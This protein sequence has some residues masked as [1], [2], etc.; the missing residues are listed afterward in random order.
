MYTTSVSLLE[1]LRQPDE[2]TAWTWF[3]KLY[4]PLLF[5]WARRLGLQEQD[6]SDLVQEMFVTLVQKLPEFQYEQAKG[7]RNWLRTVFLN[8]WRDGGRRRALP[9]AANPEE[10]LAAL[11]APEDN[12]AFGEAEYRRHLVGRALHLMQ[13][14][15][16]PKT[17][18]ACWEHVVVGRSA[19]EVAAEL[20]ITVGSVYVAKSRVLCRLRHDLAGLLD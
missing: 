10:A 3:V 4:T 18:K 12:D 17:W 13:T 14:E 15:F 2:P 7:F 5:Y 8:K 1:R 20:G 6:A 9:R 19:G 11:T 16:P